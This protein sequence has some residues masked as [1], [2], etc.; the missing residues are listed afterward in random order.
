MASKHP[1]VLFQIGWNAC[2]NCGACVSV[3]PLEENF[4]SPFDTIAV[5]RPCD[6]ACMACELICPVTTITHVLAEEVKAPVP[7]TGMRRGGEI[8]G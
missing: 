5:D 2:I 4:T 7:S 3:C 8:N 6:V 1:P